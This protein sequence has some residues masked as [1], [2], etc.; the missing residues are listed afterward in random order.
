MADERLKEIADRHAATTAGTWYYNGWGYNVSPGDV[1]AGDWL[2]FRTAE[3]DVGAPADDRNGEFVAHA[4]QDVPDLLA[5]VAAIQAE[6]DTL[7]RIFGDQ[8]IDNDA[9]SLAYRHGR[10]DLLSEQEERIREK[11]APLR[12][13]RSGI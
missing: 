4:H 13:V 6:L 5:H 3:S 7:R 9:L 1:R 2:L 11:A 10:A 8:I 12:T